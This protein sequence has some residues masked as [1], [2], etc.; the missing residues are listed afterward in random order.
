[1]IEKLKTLL[2]DR[3]FAQ[4]GTQRAMQSYAL[5]V[6]PELENLSP[7]TLKNEIQLLSDRIKARKLLSE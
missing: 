5:E 3:K 6:I 4:L 7:I 1:M 2:T